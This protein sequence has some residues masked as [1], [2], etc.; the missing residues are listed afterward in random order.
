MTRTSTA[1]YPGI[2]ASMQVG[3]EAPHHGEAASE[4]SVDR[5]PLTSARCATWPTQAEWVPDR[6]APD[7]PA[8]LA[9]MCKGCP[10]RTQCLRWA[11]AGDEQG[12]WAGTTT[13]QRAEL[14][15]RG[16][17]E[18]LQQVD[19]HDPDAGAPHAPG[20]ASEWWYRRRGCRC[21]GCK[22]ANADQRAAERARSRARSDA[23]AAA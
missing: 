1:P 12:Y 2:T 9:S 15:D 13:R 4:S 23:R 11:L 3:P 14:R 6:E 10:G 8:E 16:T 7:V 5:F 21:T 19:R 17:V 18:L 22:R 20:E